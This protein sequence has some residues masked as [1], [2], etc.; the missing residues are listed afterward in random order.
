MPTLILFVAA[1]VLLMIYYI[2][3][4]E[5]ASNLALA[6]VAYAGTVFLV[7]SISKFFGLIP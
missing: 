1:C 2:A 6:F 7:V 5:G 3:D 4:P